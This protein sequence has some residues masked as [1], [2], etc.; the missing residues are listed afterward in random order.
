MKRSLSSVIVLSLLAIS[1]FGQ[2]KH[3]SYT[4]KQFNYHTPMLDYVGT[5]ATPPA[6]GSGHSL[7]SV[8]C[9]TLD[10]DYGVFAN[11]KE[12]LGELGVGYV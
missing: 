3:W 5:V 7:W 4:W 12:Y 9:E 8:G 1:A 11:Y 10:R 6:D 2:N